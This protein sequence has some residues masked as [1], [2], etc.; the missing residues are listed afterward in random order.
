MF[1]NVFFIFS[2]TFFFTSMHYLYLVMCTTFTLKRA[3]RF[4]DEIEAVRKP[5]GDVGRR[6]VDDGHAHAGERRRR[7]RLV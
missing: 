3:V 5:A 1:F 4:T 7:T 6:V 2:G